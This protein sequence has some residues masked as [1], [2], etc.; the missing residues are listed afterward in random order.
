MPAA[1]EALP[2]LI[3][4]RPCAVRRQGGGKGSVRRGPDRPHPWQRRGAVKSVPAFGMQACS[5]AICRERASSIVRPRLSQPAAISDHSSSAGKPNA[6][7]TP[8]ITNVGASLPVHKGA[9]CP[10]PAPFPA[11]C[12]HSAALGTSIPQSGGKGNK[13]G[14][15][16][17][18]FP[19]QE[20]Q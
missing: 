2:G 7:S 4:H 13:R 18:F 19:C 14:K 11:A 1:F 17:G 9:T 16:E 8:P 5:A 3:P 10:R 12:F 15:K 20:A 6:S